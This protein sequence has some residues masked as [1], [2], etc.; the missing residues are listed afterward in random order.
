M[1]PRARKTATKPSQADGN[2]TVAEVEAA[3]DI[4]ET[5]DVELDKLAAVKDD[6]N[7]IP[8]ELQFTTKGRTAPARD[9]SD[10]EVLSVPQKSLESRQ[11][12]RRGDDEYVPD[13]SHHQHR[14]R[15][16][17]H[18]LVINRHNLLGNSL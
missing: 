4:L 5:P 11:V 1:P 13:P 6:E 10:S 17:N 12:R 3:V 18:R 2:P 8:E 9:K 15:I 16:V 14:D 7:P